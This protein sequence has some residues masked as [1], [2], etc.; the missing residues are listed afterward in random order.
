[1]EGGFLLLAWRWGQSSHGLWSYIAFKSS[2]YL[3]CDS[4]FEVDKITIADRFNKEELIV[5]VDESSD[6]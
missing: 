4:A 5:T 2:H 3:F 1:M 6:S